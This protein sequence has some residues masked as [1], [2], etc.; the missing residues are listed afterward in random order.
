[1][2]I[3]DVIIGNMALS[4]VGAKRLITSLTE[5]TAGAEAV[6]LW[7][8][9]ARLQTLEAYD[10]NFAKKRLTLA[11][12]ADAPPTEWAYRYTYPA[13]IVAVR[14]IWNPLGQIPDA[15]EYEIELIAAG[16]AKCILTNAQNAIAMCTA[17]ITTPSLF[18]PS[19]V[20]AFARK[21]AECIAY[22]LTGK[23]SIQN[24]QTQHFGLMIQQA[25]ALDASQ[26]VR[27]KPRDADW[28]RDRR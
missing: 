16:T 2:A 15:I 12:H 19:Y 24:I 4:F 23:E 9:Y 28:I 3:S 20:I 26:S 22:T 13:N 25:A 18:S 6:N 11:V 8:E 10:W 1:M 17:D 7:Y 14:S 21:L 27:P 5:D